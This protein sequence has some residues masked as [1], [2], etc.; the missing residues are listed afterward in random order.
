M[1]DP[2]DEVQK[3][4]MDLMT[5]IAAD[6]PDMAD[7]I[8]LMRAADVVKAHLTDIT[9]NRTIVLTGDIG[10]LSIDHIINDAFVK[11]D[12]PKKYAFQDDNV[13]EQEFLRSLLSCVPSYIMHAKF[14]MQQLSDAI[15]G[16]EWL[17]LP[18][19][20][21]RKCYDCAKQLGIAFKGNEVRITADG[22]C[23]H[24]R[25]FAIEVDF[26]TG[27][28][29]F[30]DWPA[31]FSEARDAGFLIEPSEKESVNY[32][33]GQRASTENYA[34]QQIVHH[35]V[36]NTC[37]SFYVNKETGAIQI[38][39]AWDEERD[40]RITPE[41]MES[42][43]A[44]CTDLWWVTMLDRKFYDAIVTKLPDEKSK[45]YYDKELHI[46]HIPPGRYRFT[47]YGQ[48]RDESEVFVTG[49]RIGDASDFMPAFD[50]LA[51]KRLM[52]LDEAVWSYGS[53]WSNTPKGNPL[54][55]RFRF[56]D[57]VFNVIGN[58]LR[59]KG[60]LFNA[61]S[62]D[63]DA[64]GEVMQ[65]SDEPMTKN[66]PYPN[67][68]KQYST[69]YSI[70]LNELPTDWL[71]G[72]LWY[73]RECKTYFEN[74]AEGY[75]SAYP[76]KYNRDEELVAHINK[77]RKEDMSEEDFNAAVSKAYGVEYTGDIPDFQTRRWNKEKTRILDFINE[78][79][80]VLKEE[81]D[82]RS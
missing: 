34:K 19:H 29:V 59:S 33:K 24:N 71:E 45:K 76:S 27:E 5:K 49:E 66:N 61:F 2:I 4:L 31:R 72:V 20:Y 75:S 62:I 51:S 46:A 64:V 50:V 21:D 40:D 55:A 28:V 7:E 1:N 52:T 79:I 22:P 26:P 67:F 74:G 77:M 14:S 25:K 32:L 47:C 38:G 11:I 8:Q 23:D 30:D 36:G 39:S 16:K 69:I 35:S 68:Q 10:H 9:K 44:F 43:G 18:T 65:S 63:K 15:D 82:K 37:P 53:R 73:Y 12:A 13:N 78:T 81:L 41:G 70:S 57:Y 54:S 42:V 80:G 48:T 60:E 17:E 58:G 6:N 56:L 3:K